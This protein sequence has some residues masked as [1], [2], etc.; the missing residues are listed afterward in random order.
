MIS[1]FVSDYEL[2]YFMC[3]YKIKPIHFNSV[4]ACMYSVSIL[5]ALLCMASIII[6]LY[7]RAFTGDKIPFVCSVAFRLYGARIIPRNTIINLVILLY[8]EQYIHIHVLFQ[9]TKN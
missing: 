3:D 1:L 6:Y 5:K 4:P 2:E 8:K 7:F 9:Y